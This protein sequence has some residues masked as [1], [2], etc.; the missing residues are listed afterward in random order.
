M[1]YLIVDGMLLSACSRKEMVL[2]RLRLLLKSSQ[3]TSEIVLNDFDT[4]PFPSE[5]FTDLSNHA[6][7]R[8]RI[9]DQIPLIAHHADE[10]FRESGRESRRMGRKALFATVPQVERIAFRIWEGNEVRG[11]RRPVIP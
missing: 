1:I 9:Y 2:F 3:C 10:I 5:T 11:N 7:S 6:A 8:E 4:N